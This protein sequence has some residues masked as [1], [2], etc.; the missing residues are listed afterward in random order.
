MKKLADVAEEARSGIEGGVFDVVGAV[1]HVTEKEI[2]LR[3]GQQ[4]VSQTIFLLDNTLVRSISPSR[5][6]PTML[7]FFLL[8]RACSQYESKGKGV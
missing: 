3:N 6:V 8:T 7:I 1:L 2:E 5:L 4:Q